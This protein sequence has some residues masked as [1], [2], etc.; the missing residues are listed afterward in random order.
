[1]NQYGVKAIF[2]QINRKYGTVDEIGTM[3]RWKII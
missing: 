1:M 3:G 2:R